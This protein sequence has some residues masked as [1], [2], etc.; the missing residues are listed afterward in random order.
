[1]AARIFAMRRCSKVRWTSPGGHGGRNSLRGTPGRRARQIMLHREE[2]A[3]HGPLGFPEQRPRVLLEDP[4][5]GFSL[6]AKQLRQLLRRQLEVA[7]QTLDV[8]MQGRLQLPLALAMAAIPGGGASLSNAVIECS[9]A[10][11]NLR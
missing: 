7:G 3:P 10:L 4:V 9:N 1:M 5:P 11:Q 6:F 2:H 8:P